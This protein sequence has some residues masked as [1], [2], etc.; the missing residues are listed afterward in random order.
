MRLRQR[1]FQPTIAVEPHA[2]RP[3]ILRLAGLALTASTDEARSLALLLADAI[4]AAGR[5]EPFGP[6][7][8]D[9]GELAEAER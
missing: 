7:S 9:S 1:Q 2:P 8:V 3:I 5:G 6:R 4:E